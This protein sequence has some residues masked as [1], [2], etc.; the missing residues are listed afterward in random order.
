MTDFKNCLC[1]L[2][3]DELS[4]LKAVTILSEQFGAVTRVTSTNTAQ[5]GVYPGQSPVP[6]HDMPKLLGLPSSYLN[7]LI[8]RYDKMEVDDIVG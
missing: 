1:R 7:Q 6:V 5:N 2:V 3:F 4:T 8:T